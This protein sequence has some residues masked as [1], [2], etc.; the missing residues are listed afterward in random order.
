MATGNLAKEVFL[1]PPLS[2]AG[3]ALWLDAAQESGGNNSSVT[4]IPDRSGNGVNLTSS[5]TLSTNFLNGNPVYNL[6]TNV[7]RNSSFTWNSYF[8]QFVVVKCAVGNW[9]VDLLNV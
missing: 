3:C 1:T 4:L 8:T 9:L 6:G 2:I 5:A 7:P